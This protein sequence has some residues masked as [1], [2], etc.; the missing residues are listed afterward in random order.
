MLTRDQLFTL[1]ALTLL[2][3]VFVGGVTWA[4]AAG[5][6]YETPAER[7]PDSECES[8]SVNIEPDNDGTGIQAEQECSTPDDDSDETPTPDP[9]DGPGT[10]V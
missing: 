8:P 3:T 1:A 2:A 9:Y 7:T 10:R 5:D 6:T 4:V